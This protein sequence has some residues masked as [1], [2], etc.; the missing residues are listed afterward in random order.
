MLSTERELFEKHF[1]QLCAGYNLPM[2]ELRGDAY[3][4]GIGKMPLPDLERL[5]EHCLGADGPERFPTV[6]VCWQLS[7]SLKPAR[8]RGALGHEPPEEAKRYE[9][10]LDTWDIQGN[11]HLGYHF[12]RVL[13][14]APHRFGRVETQ[15]NSTS[16]IRNPLREACMGVMAQAK[17][18]WAQYMRENESERDPDSQKRVWDEFIEAAER[19]CDD[20]LAG[21]LE[22]TA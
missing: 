5:V 4:R 1:G 14:R 22:L 18:Y 10:P 7:R 11:T 12:A 3:W 2:T 16:A 15:P 6:N 13:S 8:A 19:Q 17:H 21:R 20:I 9:R